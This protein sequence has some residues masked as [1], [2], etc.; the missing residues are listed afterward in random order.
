V[1]ISDSKIPFCHT[2]IWLAVFFS[3][4]MLLGLY[5]RIYFGVDVTDEAQYLSQVYILTGG[6]DLFEHDLFFQQIASVLFAP[7]IFPFV[8]IQGNT[9]SI[10]LFAR[11]LFFF[12][13][14]GVG[15]ACYFSWVYPDFPT[16]FRLNF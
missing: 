5:L 4:V 15:T 10:I 2:H 3:A 11:H 12:L 14:M 1:N 6:S 9:D 8:K 16:T 7:F 13:Y